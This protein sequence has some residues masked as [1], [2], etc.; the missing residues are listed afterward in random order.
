MVE[1]GEPVIGDAARGVSL[2]LVGFGALPWVCRRAVREADAGGRATDALVAHAARVRARYGINVEVTGEE[3]LPRTGGYVLAPN[4]QSLVD[5][6]GTFHAIIPHIDLRA[7]AAEYGRIPFVRAGVERSGGVFMERGNR[8]ATDAVLARLTEAGQQGQRIAIWPE[9]KLSPDG[10]VGRFKRGAFLV[11]IRAQIPV[12]PVA[13]DGGH[14]ILPPGSLRMRPGTLRYR[15]GA[16]LDTG[17]L[18]EDDAPAL[19]A[20]C[21]SIVTDMHAELK[22][23]RAAPSAA[24]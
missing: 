21:Q 9:G 19:A 2:L 6:L 23:Q 14:A 13:V 15:F 11:A 5:D 16:P 20:R 7:L 8:A 17:G 22:A 4:Q 18:V 12:V 24:R 3:H 1:E 10:Q